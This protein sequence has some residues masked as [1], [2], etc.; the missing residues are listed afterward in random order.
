MLSK[1]K[2]ELPLLVIPKA[3]YVTVGDL[4]FAKASP[5]LWYALPLPIRTLLG[6]LCRSL[7]LIS[8][9]VLMTESYTL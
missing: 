6:N 5:V 8:S 1:G 3:R 7:G 2:T 9:N 4:S